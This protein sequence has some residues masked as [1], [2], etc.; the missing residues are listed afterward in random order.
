MDVIG[1]VEGEVGSGGR[2]MMRGRGCWFLVVAMVM[3]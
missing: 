2:G 1:G 3:V